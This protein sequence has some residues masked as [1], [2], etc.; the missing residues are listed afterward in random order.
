VR[1]TGLV[2]LIGVH[3]WQSMLARAPW[4]MAYAPSYGSDG[5][6]LER[7]PRRAVIA[8]GNAQIRHL[9]NGKHGVFRPIDQVND[10]IEVRYNR[11][12]TFNRVGTASRPIGFH[13]E[14]KQIVQFF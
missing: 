1:V 13:R 4:W 7:A 2:N 8:R 14:E 12:S 11:G 3:C 10:C 9:P 6:L 5:R